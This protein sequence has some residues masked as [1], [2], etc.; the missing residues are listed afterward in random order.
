MQ[1]MRPRA[2]TTSSFTLAVAVAVKAKTGVFGNFCFKMPRPWIVMDQL[3]VKQKL[4]DRGQ[5]YRKFQSLQP[6]NPV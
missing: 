2:C 6:D 5:Q 4:Y 1:L 3:N